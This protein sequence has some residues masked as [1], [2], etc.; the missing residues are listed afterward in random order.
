VVGAILDKVV[1]PDVV[2]MLRPQPDAG[3]VG[4]CRWRGGAYSPRPS[5]LQ[6]VVEA[7]HR[8][9]NVPVGSCGVHF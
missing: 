1:G 4:P 8:R 7:A 6:L 5:P 9:T 2:G 3:V